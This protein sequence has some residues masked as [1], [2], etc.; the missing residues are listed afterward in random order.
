MVS[1]IQQNVVTYPVKPVNNV[2]TFPQTQII[3]PISVLPNPPV[4]FN[5]KTLFIQID[6]LFRQI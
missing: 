2:V 5:S 4:S 6:Q 1:G 3:N